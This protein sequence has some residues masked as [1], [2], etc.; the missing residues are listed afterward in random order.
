MKTFAVD[1]VNTSLL[2]LSAVAAFFLP[3]EVFL[4]SYAF[5]GPLHYL[6]EISWLEERSFFLTHKKFVWIIIA[7]GLLIFAAYLGLTPIIDSGYLV[8]VSLLIA[9]TFSL[10][11][12]FIKPRTLK[13]RALLS[14]VMAVILLCTYFLQ[15]WTIFFAILVPT[16]IHVSLFTILF[17]FQGA[18]RSK[19]AVG[20]F[21]VFFYVL[22][23]LGLVFITIKGLSYS[24]STYVTDAYRSFEGVNLQIMNMLNIGNSD[25]QWSIYKSAAGLSIMRFIAF[26]YTYHYLNWFSKVN[27]IKW[28][29]VSKRVQ[30]F[31]VCIWIGSVLLYI[32]NFEFGLV[33]LYFLSLMHVLL[34]FPLN[35]H[36]MVSIWSGFRK[37]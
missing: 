31:T 22:L 23:S 15:S 36:S 34:E 16:I 17:M 8:F 27:I 11:F 20:Y 3:F 7:A 33:V 12:L 25:V 26:A 4:F 6:T 14:G 2:L 29:A 1:K 35:Q 19:S 24:L 18:Q 5:F 10:V 9:A 30:I 32:S 21:N 13:E 37:K 28:N